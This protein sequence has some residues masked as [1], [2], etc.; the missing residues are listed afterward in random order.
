[1]PSPPKSTPTFTTDLQGLGLRGKGEYGKSLS[2]KPVSPKADDGY[3]HPNLHAMSPKVFKRYLKKLRSLQPEFKKFL[4]ENAISTSIIE[5]GLPPGNLHIRFLGQHFDKQFH[6]PPPLPEGQVQF[7]TKTQVT[8]VHP[9]QTQPI[10]QQPHR[11]GGLMYASPTYLESFFT[12]GVHPGIVLE[13]GAQQNYGSPEEADSFL[14]STAGFVGKLDKKR[15]GPDIRPVFSARSGGIAH[16]PAEL[17]AG[18]TAGNTFINVRVVDLHLER[19]PAAVTAFSSA[20]S[21]K[22]VNIRME[23]AIHPSPNDHSRTNTHPPGS[24]HYNAPEDSHQKHSMTTF[25]HHFLDNRYAKFMYQKNPAANKL[26]GQ[27]DTT[28]RT[29]NFERDATLSKLNALANN[30]NKRPEQ[31]GSPFGTLGMSWNRPSRKRNW[32]DDQWVEGPNPDKE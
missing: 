1:M 30:S 25:N 3:L 19:L 29:G 6:H 21:S 28:A 18:Q 32:Q 5:D 22:D 24:M 13:A 12:T 20:N 14:I 9:N 31:A 17:L 16:P 27:N 11:L 8:Y 2:S 23:L 26:Y 15:A 4:K 10:R 7:D